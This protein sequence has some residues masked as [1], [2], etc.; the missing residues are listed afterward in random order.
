MLEQIANALQSANDTHKSVTME[1]VEDETPLAQHKL[2]DGA[3]EEVEDV[4]TQDFQW[5]WRR[6]GEL[7]SCQYKEPGGE[8]GSL[9]HSRGIMR[10]PNTPN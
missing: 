4:Q 3:M 9:K 6:N 5:S 8:K 7:Q 1:V 2:K 10:T